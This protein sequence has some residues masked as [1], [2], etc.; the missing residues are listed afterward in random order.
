MLDSLATLILA[1]L[2]ELAPRLQLVINFDINSSANLELRACSSHVNALQESQI[3]AR[4]ALKASSDIWSVLHQHCHS[5]SH[6][7]LII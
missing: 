3:S 7:H 6:R 5:L 2:R 4:I 1:L